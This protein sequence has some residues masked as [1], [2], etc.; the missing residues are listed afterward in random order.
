MSRH[1]VFHSV[2]AGMLLLVF[3][4]VDGLAQKGTPRPSFP[5]GFAPGTRVMLLAHDPAVT[6][7]LE[8]GTAGT[9]ICCDANDCSGSLLV[10]WDLFVGGGDEVDRCVIGPVG[11]YP[12]GSAVWVDPSE[13]LLGRPFDEVGVLQEDPEGCL[14]LAVDDGD[15][16]Y[17]VID[18]EFREQW[19]VVAPGQAVRVRGWLNTTPADVKGERWC[20]PRDG[21][22]YHPIMS[23]TSWED[24]PCCDRWVCGF[25][26]G[27]RV[28]LVAESNPYGAEDLPRGTSGTII[29]CRSGQE[30]SILVSWNLWDNGG[31]DD[32]YVECTERVAGLFPPGSTWWVSVEDVAKEFTTECGEL[33]EIRFSVGDESRDI[34]G[35]GLLIKGRDLYYLPDIVAE[36]P[37]PSGEFRAVGL[38]TPYAPLPEGDVSSALSGTILHSIVMPCPEPSCCEPP[39]VEGD[40]VKLLVDEPGGAR[41]LFAG[42]TGSVVCCN[43]NDPIAPILVSWDNWPYGDD[44]DELCEPCDTRPL[45][46]PDDSAWWVACTEIERLVLPDLY[47]A[48]GGRFSPETIEAGVSEQG[49]E[50]AGVVGNKGGAGSGPF[51]V[52]IYASTDNQI[53]QEDYPIGLVSMDIEAGG[54]ASLLWMGPFPTDIPAG[55]YYI[56][57][58]IDLDDEV[59]EVDKTNNVA[60]VETG[61][62][63]VTGE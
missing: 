5:S 63:T 2:V 55:T 59:R 30:Q 12:A 42:A 48:G 31:P 62:L 49:F 40:R 20:P 47:D 11:L 38:Y 9:I 33:K 43:Q 28:V 27:D 35:V 54:D 4:G 3:V 18:Q 10:S 56:G 53:T 36:E 60:I 32:A 50:V 17:L 8:A 21:D 6:P 16:F 29:C 24:A 39:Y 14:Y 23:V 52:G 26:Y 15:V 61:Q 46:Y 37:L 34:V 13:V 45:W 7:G 58:L 41:D 57:W 19:W 1:V 51:V 25:G 44:D 22:I